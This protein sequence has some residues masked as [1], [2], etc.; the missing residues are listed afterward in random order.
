MRRACGR[1]DREALEIKRVRDGFL[2]ASSGSFAQ[3]HEGVAKEAELYGRAWDF[4]LADIT[5]PTHLWYGGR[6]GVVPATVGHY[7]VDRIPG[8]ELTTWG[9]HG[10]VSWMVRE[11]L[12]VMRTLV[13]PQLATAAMPARAA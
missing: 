5:A 1:A 13:E 2:Y 11:G 4:D 9:E 3:G 6:D 7:L 8:A 12:D 10:H